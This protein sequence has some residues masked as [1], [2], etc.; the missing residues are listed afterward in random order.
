MCPAVDQKFGVEF[1][2]NLVDFEVNVA[3]LKSEGA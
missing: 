3:L 2:M 1:R